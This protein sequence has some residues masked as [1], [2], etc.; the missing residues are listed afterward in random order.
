[1]WWSCGLPLLIDGTGGGGSGNVVKQTMT[2]LMERL[3]A[4]FIMVIIMEKVRQ[5]NRSLDRRRNEDIG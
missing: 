2:D 4:D 1:M 5:F 3:P